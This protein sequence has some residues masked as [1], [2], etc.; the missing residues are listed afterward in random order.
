MGKINL[1]ITGCMGRMGQQ[2]IKSAI[3]D[4]ST[5]LVSLTENR[6]INKKINGIRPELNTEK[7]LG[8]SLIHI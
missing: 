5:K 4:K 3:K 8:L 1:A 2:L 6:S 7:A